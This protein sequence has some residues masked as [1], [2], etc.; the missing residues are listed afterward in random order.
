MYQDLS[1]RH[2]WPVKKGIVDLP[3]RMKGNSKRISGNSSSPL[4]AQNKDLGAAALQKLLTG[5]KLRL[6]A[7][8]QRLQAVSFILPLFCLDHYSTVT[9][10]S[11]TMK[12]RPFTNRFEGVLVIFPSLFFLGMRPRHF[13]LCALVVGEVY[14]LSVNVSQLP[15]SLALIVLLETYKV[16][17]FPHFLQTYADVCAFAGQRKAK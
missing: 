17:C 1:T 2:D 16:S 5:V 11:T 13:L 7:V 12:Q 9:M 15:C 3:I 14:R 8:M 6:Q 10:N 4:A